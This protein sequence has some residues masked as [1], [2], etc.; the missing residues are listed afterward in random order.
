MRG[1]AGRA[2][3]ADA[4]QGRRRRF[5]ACTCTER[6]GTSARW[7]TTRCSRRPRRASWAGPA[8]ARSPTGCATP[9][10]AVDRSTR[11][12]A[13]RASAPAAAP[14]RT[15]T[16]ST[17]RTADQLARAAHD[18]DLVRLGH[19]GQPAR[20]RVPRRA[21]ARSR[22]GEELDYNGQPAGYADSPGGGHHLRRRARQRDAVGLADVQAAHGH[23]DGG[24]RAHEHGVAGHDRAGPDARRSGT[25]APTCCAASR[26]TATATTRATG[27]TCST[28]PARTTASAAACPRR[29]TTRRSG[30]SSSRCWPTRRSSRRRP[31]SPRRRRA[32]GGPAAGCGSRRRC[33][34]SARR[35]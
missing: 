7:P 35:T 8:S 22:R 29:P 31:T 16:R 1:R 4:A 21:P 10:A 19:G 5:D 6:A 33:S 32:R 3:R 20:L 30:R 28:C 26:W 25:R 14:T 12:R 17:A 11:T 9:C 15:A 24:P 13:S 18:A 23:P 27:S 2:R 34:G